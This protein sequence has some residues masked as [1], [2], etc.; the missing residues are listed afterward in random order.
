MADRPVGR[1]KAMTPELKAEI[2]T[3]IIDGQTVRGICANKHMP[4]RATIYRALADDGDPEFRDQYARAKDIQLYRLEDELL[5]IADAATSDTVQESKL[6]I[7]TRKWVMAKRA[8]KKY[9]DRVEQVVSAP[10]GS[11][12][13]INMYGRP[14][15]KD[16]A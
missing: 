4:D 2:C 5:E 15:P 14:E 6:Q 8:P 12:F 3:R 7:D 11:G 13:T 16:E 9:G 1:P 10:D